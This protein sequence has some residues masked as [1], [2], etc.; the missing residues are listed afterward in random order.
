MGACGAFQ[1]AGTEVRGGM[2][3]VRACRRAPGVGEGEGRGAAWCVGARGAAPRR[4][5][6]CPRGLAYARLGLAKGQPP[7]IT[8]GRVQPLNPGET[9]RWRAPA[10]RSSVARTPVK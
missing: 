2:P 8:K 1:V 5:F 7:G 9:A 6:A 4:P 10:T 3:C